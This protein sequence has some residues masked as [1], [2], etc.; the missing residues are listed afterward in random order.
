MRVTRSLAGLVA[1]IVAAVLVWWA[2]AD[3]D[4]STDAADEASSTAVTGSP[5]IEPTQL[6]TTGHPE[7]ESAGTTSSLPPSTESTSSVSGTDPD[8]G[9]AWVA[10]ADLPDEARD[11]LKDIDNGG[12]YTYDRDGVTFQNREHILPERQLGYYREFTVETPGSEDR[13]ARRIV[14]GQGGEFYYTDDH[15]ESFSRIAR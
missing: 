5:A 10:E 9:L 8:S 11:T 7:T 3:D 4:N 14:T 2:V 15:Y 12:P 1:A 13:G 6:P